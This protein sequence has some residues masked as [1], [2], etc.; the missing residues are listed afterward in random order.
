[1]LLACVIYWSFLFERAC[2]IFKSNKK[3][4]FSIANY[5]P[6]EV[7]VQ[8]IKCVLISLAPCKCKT[9]VSVARFYFW[10]TE[11][12]LGISSPG[13]G[14]AY[15]LLPPVGAFCMLPG[16]NN[17]QGNRD[18]PQDKNTNSREIWASNQV[19]IKSST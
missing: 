7:C 8:A 2:L 16:V 14:L 11:A 5:F 4:I 13:C 1:M 6:H 12:I 15:C 17:T 3:P 18:G 10:L 19:A 9:V